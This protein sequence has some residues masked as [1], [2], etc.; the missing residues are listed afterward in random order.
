[1]VPKPEAKL[2]SKT[3]V[4]PRQPTYTQAS[5]TDTQPGFLVRAALITALPDGAS[6]SFISNHVFGGPLEAVTLGPA[7][8]TATVSFLHIADCAKFID[9]TRDGLLYDKARD[10]RE[11]FAQ[12]EPSPDEERTR[13]QCREL[14]KGGATRCLRAVGTDDSFRL[15]KVREMP[16]AKELHV[17][18]LHQQRLRDGVSRIFLGLEEACEVG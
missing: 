6:E 8:N 10:G 17:E 1:M 14:T 4:L 16:L 3:R 12:V 5:T 15:S 18:M 11:L 9:G 2:K 13:V 7:P